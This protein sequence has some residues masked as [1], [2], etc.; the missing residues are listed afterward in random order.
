MASLWL[1]EIVDRLNCPS[2]FQGWVMPVGREDATRIVGK[3]LMEAGL[4][5]GWFGRFFSYF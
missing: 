1:V 3:W 5:V 4:N 2:T